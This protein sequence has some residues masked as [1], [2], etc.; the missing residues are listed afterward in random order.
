MYFIDHNCFKYSKQ[1]HSI[2]IEKCLEE[3]KDTEVVMVVAA[4]IAEV[5]VV[6]V[7]EDGEWEGEKGVVSRSNTYRSVCRCCRIV[8]LLLSHQISNFINMA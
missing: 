5:A 1:F 4:T 8:S 6:V 2:K 7:G 3:V